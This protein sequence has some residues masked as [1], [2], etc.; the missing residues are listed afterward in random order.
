MAQ[1]K[2]VR[3]SNTILQAHLVES[4][5][6]WQW[7]GEYRTLGLDFEERQASLLRERSALLHPITLDAFVF[8]RIRRLL[9][10]VMVKVFMTVKAM[11]DKPLTDGATAHSKNTRNSPRRIWCRSAIACNHSPLWSSFSFGLFETTSLN[12]VDLYLIRSKL[13]SPHGGHRRD[14]GRLA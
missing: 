4:Y 8:S 1:V 14:E 3:H 7:R 10:D 6:F 13:V 5:N 2:W 12:M 11:A 9:I